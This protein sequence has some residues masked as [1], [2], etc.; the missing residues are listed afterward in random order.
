VGLIRGKKFTITATGKANKYQM[1]DTHFCSYPFNDSPNMALFCVFDGHAGNSCATKLTR[2]F[3][4]IFVKHILQHKMEDLSLNSLWDSVYDEVDQGLIDF[5]YEG[6]TGTTLFI[7]R[8]LD[9][10]RY[11]Q[12]ANV[13]DSTC[14]VCRNGIAHLISEDHKATAKSERQ[15]LEDF[16]V[17]LEEGQTRL[18][19]L[20]VT[21]AFGDH[22]PKSENIGMISKPFVSSLIKLNSTDSWV[23]LASDGLWDIISG[24]K[25]FDIIKN[26]GDSEEASAKLVRTA[27]QSPKCTDN[28]TV[29]AV[30]L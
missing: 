4:K 28:V 27:L 7:W 1:E 6:A 10:Q 5:E 24:Q 12:C 14:F 2:L 9:G 19:G 15:R 26:T 18:G 8:A 29:V 20:G 21:R 11:L 23:V 13:G 17:K 30:K 25:A 22:F 16:G 3:P